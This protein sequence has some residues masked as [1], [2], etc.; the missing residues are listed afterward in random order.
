MSEKTLTHKVDDVNTNLRK[1]TTAL[2]ECEK[3]TGKAYSNYLNI[4]KLIE[5]LISDQKKIKSDLEF[6]KKQKITTSPSTLTRR[7][8]TI[9]LCIAGGVVVS[10]LLML[11]FIGVR[12][13]V[14]PTN[15]IKSFI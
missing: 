3:R 13:N 6:L 10:I 9:L 2:Y 15:I 8:K 14:L 1:L 5:E 4:K 12:L 7:Q 11:I